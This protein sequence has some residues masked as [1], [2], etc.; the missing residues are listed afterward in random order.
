[1]VDFS[2][3]SESGDLASGGTNRP[4]HTTSTVVVR[5][6]LRLSKSSSGSCRRWSGGGGTSPPVC[7][8]SRC[9]CQN[10]YGLW[11]FIVDI[12]NYL[13]WFINQFITGGQHLVT[14]LLHYLLI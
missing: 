7:L 10:H 14:F 11:M 4:Q 5:A 6:T 1:M 13:L 9:R 8:L 3:T 2:A 12:S